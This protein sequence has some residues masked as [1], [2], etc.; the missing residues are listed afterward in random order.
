MDGRIGIS[1]ENQDKKHKPRHSIERPEYRRL[2]SRVSRNVL[3][4]AAVGVLA[5]ALKPSVV[6]D[7]PARQETIHENMHESASEAV[8]VSQE[9]RDNL[10]SA[11]VD[12]LAR[13]KGAK[14]WQN[15][16]KGA[17]LRVSDDKVGDMYVIGTS[18]HTFDSEPYTDK[19]TGVNRVTQPIRDR[20]RQAGNNDVADIAQ[21]LPDKF[22]YAVSAPG[23]RA[24]M[25]NKIAVSIRQ[26]EDTDLAVLSLVEGSD[27]EFIKSKSVF[28][29]SNS[30]SPGDNIFMGNGSDGNPVYGEWMGG[31]LSLFDTNQ[32]SALAKIPT[33]QAEVCGTYQS[34]KFI[35]GPKGVVV[36]PLMAAF[37]SGNP[38]EA[39]RMIMFEQAT[40]V[41]VSRGSD[42]VCQLADEARDLQILALRATGY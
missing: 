31:G 18:A 40:G 15:I 9:I 35:A 42:T 26:N 21:D 34:G 22:E 23:T 19:Q 29:A 38:N 11:T 27:T 10:T 41:H 1:D 30:P 17:A 36:A 25:I 12:V 14:V 33:A 6:A 5:F 16:G 2:T 32:P 13:S 20:L 4:L 37:D 24:I 28:V 7:V 3:A 8:E 39:D